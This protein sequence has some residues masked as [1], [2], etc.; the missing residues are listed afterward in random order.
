MWTYVQILILH[1]DV[2]AYSH[3]Q[4]WTR[5]PTRTRIPV[6]CRNFTLVQNSDSDH[7]IEIYVVGTE[8]CP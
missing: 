8:I 7:L 6:L 4:I 5:L 2:M 1:V 3:C